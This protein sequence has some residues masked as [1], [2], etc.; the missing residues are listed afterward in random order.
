MILW[1][2]TY[3]SRVRWVN[4]VLSSSRCKFS[5]VNTSTQYTGTNRVHVMTKDLSKLQQRKSCVSYFPGRFLGRSLCRK[6]TNF[7]FGIY[8]LSN[9]SQMLGLKFLM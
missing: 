2:H 5:S 1:F 4:E 3:K 8:L 6:D 9:L 7:V